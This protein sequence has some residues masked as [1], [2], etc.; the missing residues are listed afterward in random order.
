MCCH[1][2]GNWLCGAF[3][4]D[5]V[6]QLGQRATTWP[7]AAFESDC[8]SRSRPTPLG[9]VPPVQVMGMRSVAR[10]QPGR[11]S[12]MTAVPRTAAIRASAGRCAQQPLRGSQRERAWQHPPSAVSCNAALGLEGCF[13]LGPDIRKCCLKVCE[14]RNRPFDEQGLKRPLD[15]PDRSLDQGRPDKVPGTM[16]HA[17]D[18]HLFVAQSR[19]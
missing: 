8:L 4:F 14:R 12:P 5:R 1:F 18:E 6:C 7:H 17:R 13:R 11:R 10:R 2:V 16:A 15:L 9:S 3:A 19:E